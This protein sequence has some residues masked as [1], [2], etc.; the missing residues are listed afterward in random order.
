M[1]WNSQQVENKSKNC[2]NAPVL[3]PS[4]KEQH[5]IIVEWRNSCLKRYGKESESRA[6]VRINSPRDSKSILREL[7]AQWRRHPNS[8]QV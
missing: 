4:I 7:T 6:G 5:E 3:L 8:S 2:F 1:H